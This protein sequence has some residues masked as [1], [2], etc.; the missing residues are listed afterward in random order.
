MANQGTFP[1]VA[2]LTVE[3]AR[4]QAQSASYPDYVDDYED[5]GDQGYEDDPN[6]PEYPDNI[7]G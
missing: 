5:Y 2:I 1:G 6:I 7:V 3:L 4:G